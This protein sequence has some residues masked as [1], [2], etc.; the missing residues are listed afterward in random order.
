MLWETHRLRNQTDMNLNPDYSSTS[1]QISSL[2]FIVVK[3]EITVPTMADWR[4]G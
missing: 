4:K 1:C 3:L 2:H